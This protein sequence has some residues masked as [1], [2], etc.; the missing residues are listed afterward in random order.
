MELC[1][2]GYSLSLSTAGSSL[3]TTPHGLLGSCFSHSGLQGSSLGLSNNLC[4]R[5]QPGQCGVWDRV[6][7]MAT[8]GSLLHSQARRAVFGARRA[9]SRWLLLGIPSKSYQL[10]RFLLTYR[11]FSTPP[12]SYSSPN[13]SGECSTLAF[14]ESGLFS[15][16]LNQDLPVCYSC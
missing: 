9:G 6:P 12:Q 7:C 2:S 4:Q 8:P 15:Q 10:A 3:K 5:E 16:A 1:H 11:D 14:L 13:I